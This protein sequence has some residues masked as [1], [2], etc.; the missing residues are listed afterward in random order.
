MSTSLKYMIAALNE[1]IA[2]K[3]RHLVFLSNIKNIHFLKTLHSCQL[4]KNVI[5]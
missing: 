1:Y 2:A 4:K 5:T 3:L